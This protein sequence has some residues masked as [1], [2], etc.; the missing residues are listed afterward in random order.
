MNHRF[1]APLLPALLF[2]TAVLLPGAAHAERVVTEDLVG[3]AHSLTI[4]WEGG[5]PS[6]FVPAPAET[7]VDVVRTVAAHG[8]KRLRVAVQLRDLRA[9][10]PRATF[11]DVVVVTPDRSYS[12]ELSKVPGH[13]PSTDFWGRRRDLVHCRAALRGRMD[14]ASDTLEVSLPTACLGT[15]RWVRLGVQ[16][17]GFDMPL[18]PGGVPETT[19]VD[20]GHRDTFSETNTGKGPKIHRG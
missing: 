9:G 18:G 2:A 6:A 14:R 1:G 20:D 5:A 12:L 17:S 19:Y 7:S 11:L 13:R 3:D 16:V 15:P 10:H 4:D 8:A